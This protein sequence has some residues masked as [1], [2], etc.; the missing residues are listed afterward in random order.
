MT[1]NDKNGDLE[2]RIKKDK[3]HTRI[4]KKYIKKI[5]CRKKATRNKNGKIH[6]KTTNDD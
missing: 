6:K 2:Q 3:Q 1:Q 5:R 4:S